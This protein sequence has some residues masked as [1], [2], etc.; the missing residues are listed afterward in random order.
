MNRLLNPINSR[1]ARKTKRG[2]QARAEPTAQNLIIKQNFSYAAD[3]APNYTRTKMASTYKTVFPYLVDHSSIVGVRVDRVMVFGDRNGQPVY[4]TVGDRYSVKDIAGLRD[5]AKHVAIFDSGSCDENTTIAFEGVT[6][7]RI[8]GVVYIKQS[9]LPWEVRRNMGNVTTL[10]APSLPSD[11][12][13]DSPSRTDLQLELAKTRPSIT[14]TPA[15]NDKP[16]RGGLFV[17]PTTIT[18]SRPEMFPPSCSPTSLCACR[19]H[20]IQK[21]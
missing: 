18:V 5:R 12:H 16:R 3:T 2:D 9:G 11:G 17:M 10:V 7:L 8:H 1:G 4:L 20:V 6:H 21:D 19:T 15:E 14:I 13:L